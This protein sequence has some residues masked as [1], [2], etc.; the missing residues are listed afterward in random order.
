MLASP[1]VTGSFAQHDLTNDAVKRLPCIYDISFFFF[2]DAAFSAADVV[3]VGS[4]A[5]KLYSW[6][7]QFWEPASY[8][9]FIAGH[10]QALPVSYHS[11]MLVYGALETLT[12]SIHV[13]WCSIAA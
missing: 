9:G 4:L 10:Q 1:M 3:I 6:N 12:T 8:D 7:G 2:H 13:I 11:C 5:K